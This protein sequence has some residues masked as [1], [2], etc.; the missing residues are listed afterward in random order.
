MQHSQQQHPFTHIFVGRRTFYLFSITDIVRLRATARWLTDFF[1][2]LQLRQR[3]AHSL[4][5]Q[6]GLRRAANRQPPMQLLAVDDQEMNLPDLLVAVCIV[7]EGSWKEMGEVFDLAG[8]CGNCQ[9]PVR[10]TVA[11]LHR[12]VSRRAYVS[13]PRVLAQLKMVGHHIHFGDGETFQVFQ[14]GNTV[15]AIK[16][17]NGFEV[18]V[19]PDLPAGHLCLQ[20]RRQHDPPVSSRI[21]YSTLGWRLVYPAATHSSVSSFIKSTILEHFQSTHANDKLLRSIDRRAD[22][23][24]LRTLIT[25]S[26]HTPLEGCTTTTTWQC[27]GLEFPAFPARHRYLV[28]TGASD[29]FV[30]WI[31]MWEWGT[32]GWANYAVR[33]EVFTTEKPLSGVGAAFKDRFPETTR[34]ARVVLWPGFAAL[35]FDR[36]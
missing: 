18:T 10:L 9:L 35:V 1:R 28:L 15:R 29:P 21:G 12:F 30:A 14:H 36:P 8:L 20:H 23:D 34:L 17:D 5:T 27:Y 25:Q 2:A 16:D 33:V 6:A 11:D 31:H 26:P 24:R 22:S 32:Y 4:R 3:L 7:E 19:D 13:G